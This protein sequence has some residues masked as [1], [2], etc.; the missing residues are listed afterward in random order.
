M[1]W[2]SRAALLEP[3][4][5]ALPSA[6]A[7]QEVHIWNS[8]SSIMEN[9]HGYTAAGHG[10]HY[11]TLDPVRLEYVDKAWDRRCDASRWAKRHG[12]RTIKHWYL[13]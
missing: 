13:S 3:M 9:R 6:I 1:E 7:G 4:Q 2:K 11:I 8:A 10:R 12:A 5:F